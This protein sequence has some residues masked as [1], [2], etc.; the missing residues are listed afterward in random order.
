MA[1]RSFIV[2]LVVAAAAV[3]VV[4]RPAVTTYCHAG[5]RC[6]GGRGHDDRRCWADETCKRSDNPFDAPRAAHVRPAAAPGN[7]V[8]Y[9]THAERVAQRRREWNSTPDVTGLILISAQAAGVAPRSSFPPRAQ[10]APGDPR[11]GKMGGAA[12]ALRRGPPAARG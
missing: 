9:R 4:H 5:R 3:D 1:R 6:R 7:P 2:A 12:E 10:T 8:A 11:G